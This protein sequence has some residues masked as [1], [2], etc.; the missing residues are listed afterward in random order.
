MAEVAPNVVLG[1]DSDG[2]GCRKSVWMLA[3]RDRGPQSMVTSKSLELKPE[4][5][6]QVVGSLCAPCVSFVSLMLL[7]TPWVGIYGSPVDERR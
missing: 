4:L 5:L 2:L 6:I 3:E 7:T 1:L